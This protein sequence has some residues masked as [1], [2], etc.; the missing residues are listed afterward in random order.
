MLCLDCFF[1]HSIQFDW[2]AGFESVYEGTTLE[3]V[4]DRL[5]PGTTYQVRVA[6]RGPGGLSEPSESTN[7]TTDPVCPGPC[8]PPRLHGR[9]R[10]YSLT[11]KFSE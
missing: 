3:T 1:L 6:A 5:Q 7:I 9:A 11:L 4:C 2:F 10:P 8:G